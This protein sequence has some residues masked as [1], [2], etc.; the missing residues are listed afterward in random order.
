[1]NPGDVSITLDGK[2]ETLR[3]TLRAARI[4]NSLGGFAEAFKLLSAFDMNAYVTIVAAGLN[5]KPAEIEDA[6]YKT[7][8]VEITGPLAEFVSLLTNGGRPVA[9]SG[10][11]DTGESR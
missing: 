10:D 9:P 1:M 11:A 6:V 8:L 4:V 5:R 2:V 7:G 3:C